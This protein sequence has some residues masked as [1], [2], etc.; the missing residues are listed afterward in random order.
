[1]RSIVKKILYRSLLALNIIAELLAVLFAIGDNASIS[2][3]IANFVLLILL[4]GSF[5]LNGINIFRNIQDRQAEIEKHKT[6]ISLI[7]VE[8]KKYELGQIEDKKEKLLTDISNIK[9]DIGNLKQEQ[10]VKKI[11]LAK[12]QDEYRSKLDLQTTELKN[13]NDNIASAKKEIANELSDKENKS[14]Q[15]LD[16]ISA[17]HDQLVDSSNSLKELMDSRQKV[18]SNLEEI[19]DELKRSKKQLEF[20]RQIIFSNEL[21]N[22]RNM[23]G[24]EFE[25]FVAH[26]LP[27]SGYF[28]VVR[29]QNSG[30]QGIDVTAKDKYGSYGIQCKLYSNYVGNEAVQE[31]IAGR[32]F[33]KLDFGVVI[34][35]SNFTPS[36]RKLAGAS[37]VQ[38]WGMPELEELLN[39]AVNH[40]NYTPFFNGIIL[41]S[42]Y[43][44]MTVDLNN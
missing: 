39:H 35:N 26:L 6:D 25:H 18:Y 12:A 38:L 23:D 7:D 28:D 42:N 27:Y 9:S 20:A 31:V 29:T 37:N 43:Q 5:Q 10:D 32:I 22:L 8:K 19:K 30:D 44:S 11:E 16:E 24:F 13:L 1:M 3:L 21:N 14:S 40:P 34:T 41:D 4:F 17:L 2:S 36:A 15:L 33:Y